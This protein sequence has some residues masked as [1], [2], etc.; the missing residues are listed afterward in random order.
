M[1]A[2]EWRD[3]WRS[4]GMQELRLVLWAAWDPIGGTP[5]DEY[6]TYAFRIAS[7]LGSRASRDAIAEEL[8]RIR[9]DAIGVE[10]DPEQDAH[11]AEKV[12][13]WFDHATRGW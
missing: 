9:R 6:G 4:R 1:S 2:T 3:F 7:L 11:A 13:D 5:P 10:A 8:G 12:G